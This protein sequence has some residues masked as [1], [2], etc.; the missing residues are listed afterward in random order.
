MTNNKAYFR[1][2]VNSV[3]EGF[4]KGVCTDLVKQL[5]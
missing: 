4:V 3:N 1:I 2:L 5:L